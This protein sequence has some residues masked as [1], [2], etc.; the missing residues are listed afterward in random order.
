[1]LAVGTIFGW[2]GCSASPV[3]Y[4]VS[5]PGYTSQRALRPPV[6]PLPSRP[7]P[8]KRRTRGGVTV[9]AD[10]SGRVLEG[11]ANL[12]LRSQ[13]RS[14]NAI[15]V[16]VDASTSGVMQGALTG[17]VVRGIG[18][19]SPLGL[20][21]RLLEVKVGT[22]E[23]DIA[24]TL[25]TQNIQLSNVPTGTGRVRFTEADFGNF[26]RHPLMRSAASTAVEGFPFDFDADTVQL[27][28]Q[29]HGGSLSFAGVWQRDG[30]RYTGELTSEPTGDVLVTCSSAEPSQDAGL[31]GAQLTEF[32][33]GLTVELDG[34]F[35]TF[36]NLKLAVAKS[37]Q[38]VIDLQV[39]VRVESFPSLSQLQF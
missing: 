32:F 12:A 11:I 9:L 6:S 5:T 22:A 21:A 39:T 1:M 8:R 30:R 3:S 37:G 26:L 16:K 36:S 19:E 35:F 20:S 33:R 29:Q 25:Q 15:D 27:R 38:P 4:S 23:V 18:W 2:T 28:V 31:V 34:A 14:F 10:M 7:A 24:R 17:A 13:L